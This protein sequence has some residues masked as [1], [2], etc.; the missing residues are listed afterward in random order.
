MRMFLIGSSLEALFCVREMRCFLRYAAAL[1]RW[2][3]LLFWE[4]DEMMIHVKWTSLALA[5]IKV[6]LMFRF[7]VLQSCSFMIMSSEIQIKVPSAQSKVRQDCMRRRRQF[8]TKDWNIFI[9]CAQPTMW[10]FFSHFSAKSWDLEHS[11]A[12]TFNIQLKNVCTRCINEQKQNQQH[13]EFI[14]EKKSFQRV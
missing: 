4:R 13:R 2:F 5:M 9:V 7:M 11:I 3:F 14:D 10:D 1:A 12:S 8:T 6:F